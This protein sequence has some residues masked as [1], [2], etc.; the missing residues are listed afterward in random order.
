MEPLE[1]RLPHMMLLWLTLFPNILTHQPPDMTGFLEKPLKE[2]FCK[3]LFYVALQFFT[4]ESLKGELMFLRERAYWFGT[5]SQCNSNPKNVIYWWGEMSLNSWTAHFWACWSFLVDFAGSQRREL[6]Q[7][8]LTLWEYITVYSA[9][10]CASSNYKN[11]K[12][13][14]STLS[15]QFTV[16]TPY[17]NMSDWMK[18]YKDDFS[19]QGAKLNR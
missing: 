10:V 19:L 5:E 1:V 14:F 16:H 18:L 4:P 7:S 9:Q 13:I 8:P 6:H 3:T 15:L 11:N 17:I 12:T 2:A